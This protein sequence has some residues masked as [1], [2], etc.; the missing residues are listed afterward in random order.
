MIES[1]KNGNQHAEPDFR[2]FSTV[3]NACAF[4]KTDGP[5]KMTAFKIARRVFK[6]ILSEKYGHPSDTTF[7]T[8]LL[9]CQRL[10][11][12]G[13]KRDQLVES[14]FKESCRYGLVNQRAVEIVVSTLSGRKLHELFEGTNLPTSYANFDSGDIPIEWRK[15]ISSRGFSAKPKRN[16]R[17]RASQ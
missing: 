1:H 10:V 16:F 6:E 11:P 8:F 4:T 2:A 13:M 7:S 12:N 14:V 15:N 3:L 17:G 5:G 9:A